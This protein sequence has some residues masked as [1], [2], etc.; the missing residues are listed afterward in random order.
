MSASQNL[1]TLVAI[2]QDWALSTVGQ[3]FS[4]QLGKML[5]A[6]RNAGVP[7]PYLGNR[8]VQWDRIDITDLPTVP[9]SPSDIKRFR[10]QEGDILVCEGGEVGRAAIWTAPLEECYFQKALHRLRPLRSFEPRL[11]V[12]ILR[13]WAQAGVLANYVT[14]TS[15]A[16]LPRDKF[17]QVPIPRPPEAEQ[18]AIASALADVDALLV[19]LERLVAKKRH[20]HRGAM[21]DLLTGR[22][23]LRGFS[24]PWTTS[25]LGALVEIISGGT[26]RTNE[27]SYWGGGIKWCTPSDITRFPGKYLTHTERTLSREGLNNSGA[28]LLPVGTL[29]L[30]SRA[31]IG[32]VKIAGT[33]ICTNQ[34]FKSLVCR[35][36]INSEFLYYKLLT[37][38]REMVDRALGSTFLEISTRNV[39]ALEIATPP[40]AEQEAIAAVLSDMDAELDAVEARLRKTRDLKQAMMQELLTGRTRL[41]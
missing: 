31:T 25:P 30:C 38:K 26:P 35:A 21:Q 12:A 9:M 23:R 41:I 18:R 10:L 13:R 17:L 4:V 36:G 11:L 40:R 33:E 1:T 19:E 7:K 37:M 14:Q 32:E 8:A 3:E 2:P 15:I 6:E 27:A 29:L 5:D 39:S 16:H 22:T 28:R 24:E 20:I 34:G